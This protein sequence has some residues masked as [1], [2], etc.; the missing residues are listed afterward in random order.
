M[1]LAIGEGSCG[2]AA[3]ARRVHERLESLNLDGSVE[4]GITGCI[5]ACFLEPIVDVYDGDKLVRRLVK[6]DEKSA[7]R[8]Y[9]AA[10][11]GDLE[12]VADLA[13]T[14]EDESFLTRQTRIALRHCGL[15]DPESLAAYRAADGYRAIAKVLAEMTPE[16]VIE[17]I[18]T[19]GLAGRGGAGFPTWFKWNAA[20]NAKGERKFLICNAD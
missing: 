17:E 2:I 5:G 11:S 7:E 14:P 18:K 20:R 3:G 6:I 15:I 19:S 10:K 4:I 12:S 9:A 16:Q 1:R 13:I 8:V